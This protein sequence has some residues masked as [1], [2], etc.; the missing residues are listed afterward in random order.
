MRVFTR[1]VIR[2]SDG[3]VLSRSGFD[4]GG[5]VAMCKGGSGTTVDSVDEAYNAGMLELSQEEWGVAQEYANLFKYG[6][7]YDPNEKVE[8]QWIDG[9]WFNADDLTPEQVGGEKFIKNPEYV[10]SGYVKDNPM[11]QPRYQEGSGPD[12]PEYILNP[13][14]KLETAKLGDVKGYDPNAQV[15]EMQL[16]LQNQAAEAELLPL[17]TGLAKSQIADT[18]AAIGEYAPVRKAFFG[19]ALN[20]PN[21]EQRADQAQAGVEHAFANTE[22]D[23]QRGLFTA[24]VQPGSESMTRALND[25]SI[26]KATGIAGARTQAKILA[27]DELFNKLKSAT[28]LGTA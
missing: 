3:R 10:P 16:I 18:Q 27:E 4:Y 24:G 26:A 19:A 25:R 5:P 21:A 8:G 17:Q 7:D 28:A 2:I 23:F 12:V 22:K 9:E 11:S 1:I 6:V 14:Y 15:S 13:D 20:G